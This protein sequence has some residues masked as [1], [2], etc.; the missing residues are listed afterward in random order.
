MPKGD[1]LTLNKDMRIYL[2]RFGIIAIIYMKP[3]IRVH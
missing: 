3:S 2:F 1:Y